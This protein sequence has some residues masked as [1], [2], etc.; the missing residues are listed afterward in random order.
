VAE[1]LVK[2]ASGL[3]PA[4]WN[5][6]IDAAAT[7]LREALATGGPE[8]VAVL[9]GA[10][11]SNEDAFM[12]AQLADAIGTPHR[13]AQ[14]G[15]GLPVELLRLPRATIG[16]AAN[17][18]TIVLI[19][20]DI[21]EELPVLYLRLRDAAEKRRSRILE[22]SPVETGLSEYAWKSV[23]VEAGTTQAIID[24]LGSEEVRTQLGS[25]DVVVVAGRANLAE[26]EGLAA[27]AINS[28]LAACPGATVLPALRRGNVVGALSVGMR[29]GEGGLD[30]LGILQAAA[31]GKLECLVLLGCDP[32][33]DCPDADLA[34]QALAGARRVISVDTHL[35]DSTRLA[36]VVLAAAAFGE[37]AGT[38][39]NIEGRVQTLG[40]KI[41]PV[42]TARPDWMIAVEVA[43]RLGHERWLLELGR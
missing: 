15:D 7:L 16:Q 9:G 8:S 14:L 6:A 2:T 1:P 32:L 22:F 10:R 30:G 39:T 11:G 21:K 37:K 3:E 26:S 17:A 31:S 35:S 43:D 12:W 36:D 28:V 29:P 24:T 18:A 20:P 5:A 4:S 13:D 34:R 41:T 25:G 38:T 40:H 19:G 33:N 23:R 42:G 27:A